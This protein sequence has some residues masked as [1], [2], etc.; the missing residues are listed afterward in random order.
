MAR[1]AK[2]RS[3]DFGLLIT[4]LVL[5][6]FGVVMVFSA[7]YYDT[8][9]ASG[10]PYYYLLRMSVWFVAGLILMIVLSV[11]KYDIYYKLAPYL[12]ILSI[13]LL[14]LLFTP[15]GAERNY[16][17]RWIEIG[18]VTFMPAE[19]AKLAAIIFVAWYYAKYEKY[20]R[21]F[22]KGVVPMLAVA[23]LYFV[24]IYLQPNL[25]TAIIICGI[26]I[27]MMFIAG[28]R[29][30]YFAGLLAAG[31]IGVTV[32]IISQGEFHLDRVMSF[33]DP[34]ADPQGASYQVIQS[35]LALATGSVFGV[36]PG[37]SI[38]K[39]QYLPEA[40]ND[41]IFA[42]IGEEYGFIGC[43]VVMA[44]FII[45]IWKGAMV[46]MNAANRFGMLLAA[47]I[48]ILFALQVI[49]N[50]AVVTSVMPPTGVIL[51]FIS[52]G[53]NA[54][55][56]FSAAAGILLNISKY[57]KEPVRKKAETPA[58]TRETL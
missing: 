24:L 43:L 47:G 55:L 14:C 37:N 52:Y 44:V 51:P 22:T 32:L 31:I 7:S 58:V 26:I 46:S 54:M 33:L 10:N 30:S 39:A 23:G 34:F 1:A 45:L 53:G 28:I 9:S 8:I 36:G 57:K 17:Y 13:I 38:Q 3:L 25:S 27:G 29:F 19:V 15:L 4:V 18:P 5:M 48:T 41:F 16:A 42:I 35:L 49:M 21:T 40:Q 20:I 12:M 11:I 6:I 2:K 56:V 50:I